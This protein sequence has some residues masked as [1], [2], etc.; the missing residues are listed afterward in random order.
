MESPTS[1]P[2]Y[3]LAY[4]LPCGPWWSHWLLCWVNQDTLA[5]CW[6]WQG[7][8]QISSPVPETAGGLSECS[9]QAPR[10]KDLQEVVPSPK[11]GGVS[12]SPGHREVECSLT[13]CPGGPSVLLCLKDY[14][15]LLLLGPKAQKELVATPLIPVEWGLSVQMVIQSDASLSGWGAVVW[16]GE[17]WRGS[18]VQWLSVT[19][20]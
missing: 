20:T 3:H 16:N 18:T 8:G 19:F 15:H 7:P 17:Q 5:T 11:Q 10:Q 14:D 1:S 9:T 4:L 2:A 13:S 6:Y 12:T